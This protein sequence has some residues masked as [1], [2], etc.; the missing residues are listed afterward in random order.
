[1]DWKKIFPHDKVYYEIN[2]GIL[3]NDDSLELLKILPKNSINLIYIDP[4]YGIDMDKKFGLP[5]WK[6]TEED[7]NFCDSIGLSIIRKIDQKKKSNYGM[8]SYIKFMY[9]R[10]ILMKDILTDDGSIYV[11]LDSNMSHYIKI[12]MDKIFK[13]EN[14]VNEIVWSY[15]TGGV[16]K[17]S[18][19]KKHDTI[20]LYRKSKKFKINILYERQYLIKSFMNS[21]IDDKGNFYTDTLLRDIIEGEI[22][23]VRDD[24][25]IT[26]NTR[27]VLNL[28]KEYIK[29]DT[30]KPIGLLKLLF[31][32]ASNT[33]SIIADFFAG[34]GTALA[35]AE[36]LNRKWIGNDINKEACEIIKQ[37]MENL[38]KQQKLI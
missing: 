23:I 2:N 6:S 15:R 30:Q 38:T 32:I 17:K 9:D 13:K 35:V 3:Y 19:S 1:M 26:Y 25:I 7:Y 18:L 4:P 31:E 22:N 33:N 37:R 28:S 12:I 24:K 29:F 27:P 8:A 34:S 14:F 16:S 5:R 36:K 21:K 10:F 11:H 20:F